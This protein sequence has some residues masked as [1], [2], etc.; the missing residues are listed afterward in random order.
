MSGKTYD[1]NRHRK[2]YP[3]MRK[4]PAL[5]NTGTAQGSIDIETAKLV[6]NDEYTKTYS[7]DGSIVYN[8]VPVVGAT[9][10]DSNV[11][12]FITNLSTTSVTIESY[13]NFTG[14]VHLQIFKDEV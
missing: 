9:V 2:T 5:L 7:F 12:V 10:E 8:R 3:F 13:S 1:A 11:M 14:I 4:R 6:F